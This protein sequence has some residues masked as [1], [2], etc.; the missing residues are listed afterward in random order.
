[1]PDLPRQRVVIHAGFHKTGTSSVQAVLREN[2]KLLYPHMA[3][4]V[5][6]KLE[7]VL[8]AA[9]GFSTW[10]DPISLTKAGFRFGEYLRDLNL[11]PKRQLLVSA[12][13]MSGHMAGRGDIV[14]YSAA[15]DLMRAY[16]D[17]LELAY[18]DRLKLT[19]FFTLRRPE[20]WIK[21]AYW[22]HVKSARL[23]LDF[24]EFEDRYPK[25]ANFGPIID[26]ITEMVAPHGVKTAWLEDVGSLPLGPATP[27][28]DLL[29][30]PL[31]KK[32]ALLPAPRRNIRGSDELL[33]KFLEINRSEISSEAAKDHKQALF[34]EWK[35]SE[36][37]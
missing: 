23:T 15:P 27:I 28:L 8:A 37:L 16:T 33:Q 7:P 13:E 30:L 19:F 21:S 17:E 35:A 6:G 11:S 31:H 34:E 20:T 22:E 5:R 24:E 29:R 14:D 2:R 18:G 10:R 1:M 36:G 12:E 26:R 4:G 25:A 3:L 32:E 9:R